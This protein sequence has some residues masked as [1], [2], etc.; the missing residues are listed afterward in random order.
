MIQ[1]PLLTIIR[2]DEHAEPDSKKQM[3]A[4]NI[5]NEIFETL[6]KDLKMRID[7][8][9]NGEEVDIIIYFK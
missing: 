1:F 8:I 2:D 5:L 9:L 4:F 7:Q 6:N 3:L